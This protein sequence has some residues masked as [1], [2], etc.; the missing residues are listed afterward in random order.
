[1]GEITEMQR[2]M[3]AACGHEVEVRL[4]GGFRPIDDKRIK[5]TNPLVGKCVNFTKPLDND[6]EV[7][8]FDIKV[9]GFS[10]IYEIIE[11]EIETLIIKD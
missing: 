10:S 3:Y 8:S 4:V 6:P 2:K 11:D 9:P 7:A 1:M 5:F